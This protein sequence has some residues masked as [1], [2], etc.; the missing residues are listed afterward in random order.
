MPLDNPPMRMLHY[1]SETQRAIYTYDK[2][3]THVYEC[4]G[5]R[6]T[7]RESRGLTPLESACPN[8]NS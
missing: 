4:K 8:T 6:G 5:L 3:K 1:K 2:G 7:L